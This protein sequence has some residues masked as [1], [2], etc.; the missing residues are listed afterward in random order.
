MGEIIQTRVMRAAGFATILRRAIFA[1]F[2]KKVDSKIIARDAA[3]LNRTIFDELVKRGI[4]KEDYIKIIVEGEFDKERQA[5]VWKQ[6]EIIKYI[7]ETELDEIRKKYSKIEEEVK[8]LKKENAHLH[9][10]LEALVHI[11]KEAEELKKVI[12]KRNEEIKKLKKEVNKLISERDKLLQENEKL[13][14][15]LRSIAKIITEIL[16]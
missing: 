5:I 10:E 2:S 7:P 16:R 6:I 9:D 11:R 15:V 3:F 12:N 8:K 13:K 14:E 4:R 1:V